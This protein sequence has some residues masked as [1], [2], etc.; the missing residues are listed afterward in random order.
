MNGFIMFYCDGRVDWWSQYL[1]YKFLLSNF[2]VN[3]WF[4]DFNKITYSFKTNM[5][6]RTTIHLGGL[7]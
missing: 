3:K 5:Q 2:T 1:P 6:P 4:K 7:P